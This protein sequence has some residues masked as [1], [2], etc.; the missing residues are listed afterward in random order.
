MQNLKKFIR[1]K[2]VVII[3]DRHPGFL[4]SVPEIF[5]AEN[6]AYCYRHLKKNFSSYFNKHNTKGNKG[7]EN[8]LE[9]LDK[10]V[11]ARVEIDYNYDMFEL[12]KYN[13][14]FAAWI[15]KNEHEHWAMS[16]FPKKRWDKIT[17]NLAESF[18]DWLRNE[19]HHSICSFII[20]HM[21]KL[22]AMLIKHKAESNAWK[23]IIGLKIE[24]KVKINIAKWEVYLVVHSW[25]PFMLYL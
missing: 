24:E 5:G 17:T 1:E 20:E 9:W 11:Y 21:T 10:I 14:S 19:P 6:H 7:K 3:S 12:Q 4:C 13:E 16:K 22:G 2:E 25:K 15:E 23:G 18:N 8:A